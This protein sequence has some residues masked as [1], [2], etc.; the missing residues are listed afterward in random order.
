[1]IPIGSTSQRPINISEK[2]KIVQNI[3]DK[4]S[5]EVS[6]SQIPNMFSI[7]PHFVSYVALETYI[8]E[9]ISGLLCLYVWNEYFYIG[10][11]SN[12]QFFLLM[13]Q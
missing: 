3:K 1:M 12:F 8:G 2:R 7:A 9:R 5:H 11:S 10:E 6:Q 13:G 4:S